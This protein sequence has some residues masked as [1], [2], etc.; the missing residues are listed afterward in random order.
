MLL[1]RIPILY[2]YSYDFFSASMIVGTKPFNL[3]LALESETAGAG[4]QRIF[5]N[6]MYT[7]VV[8]YING[9]KVQR[10][11]EWERTVTRIIYLN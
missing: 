7:Y 11:D 3:L 2:V 6:N 4:D 9:K 10:G 5:T 1:Q 8:H